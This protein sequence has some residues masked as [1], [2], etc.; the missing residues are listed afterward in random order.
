MHVVATCLTRPLSRLLRFEGKLD[1][2]I[3]VVAAVGIYLGVVGLSRLLWNLDLWPWLGVRSG[4]SLF[5]DTRNI[6]AAVECRRLGYDPLV[7]NPC[8]PW[9]RPMFYPR[10]WLLLRWIGLDQSHTVALGALI[11]GLFVLC[12]CLVIGRIGIGEGIVVAA[13][14]CSPAAMF[15]VERANMD[16][17]MFCLVAL[18]VVVWRRGTAASRVL[19]PAL[20]LLAA[21]GKLYPVLGL[22]AYV[23]SRNRRGMLAAWACGLAFVVYLIATFEDVKTVQ[24]T[25]IQGQYDSYGAR[26]LISSLYHRV[27]PDAWTGGTVTKQLLALVPLALLAASL[28]VWSR[29]RLLIAHPPDG[30]SGT[31]LAFHL[32]AFIFVG[33]FALANNYDY[34]LVFLLLTLPQLCEWT[35]STERQSIRTALASLGL[36]AVL[37]TLWISTLSERLGLWDELVT[38]VAAGLLLSLC[39]GSITTASLLAGRVPKGAAHMSRP[40]AS[41]G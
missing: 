19:S 25:A 23:F 2:R 16:L 13:A 26:I 11:V 31:L 24:R 27:I 37:A 3:V 10:I 33:T 32:G 28:L 1:G 39:A 6:T 36:A 8:D 34:R 30:S 17:V 14:V 4:P 22:P 5:F 15:A 21:T 9:E 40:P 35:R 29:R 7:A 38:W 18:A 12:V 41:E 20:V